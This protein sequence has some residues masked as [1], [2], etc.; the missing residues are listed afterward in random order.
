MKKNKIHRRD[1]LIDS[2]QAAMF[3]PA[4]DTVFESLLRSAIQPKMAHAASPFKTFIHLNLYAAPPRWMYDLFLNP[5]NEAS[6]FVASKQVTNRYQNTTGAAYTDATYSLVRYGTSGPYVPYLWSLA[7]PKSG[8][9]T[10]AANALLANMLNIRGIN[11]LNAAHAGAAELHQTAI[12]GSPTISS[13]TADKAVINPSFPTRNLIRSL[14][15]NGGIGNTFRSSQGHSQFAHN[16]TGNN[17]LAS[18]FAALQPISVANGFNATF[19]ANRSA[20]QDK[21]NTA[22]TS[23]SPTAVKYY[24][25]VLSASDASMKILSGNAI[26]T[27]TQLSNEWTELFGKYKALITATL[28]RTYNGINDK[29]I[30]R[31][32]TSTAEGRMY[33]FSDGEFAQNKTGTN[34]DLRGILADANADI[35]AGQF[36][37]TEFLVTRQLCPSINVTIPAFRNVRV[38]ARSATMSF[39]Q[40]FTGS[41]PGIFMNTMYYLSYTS[42]LLELIRVLKASNQFNDTLIYMASEFNRAARVDGSGADHGSMAGHV[43]L[44]SGRINAFKIIGNIYKDSAGTNTPYQANYKGTWGGGAPF[45]DN[46]HLNIVQVWASIMRTLGMAVPDIPNA[47]RKNRLIFNDVGSLSVTSLYNKAPLNVTNTSR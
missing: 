39:D 42:C 23:L 38:N 34:V 20:L 27:F 44:L 3:L 36:A 15:L 43:S 33:Q 31:E 8:G 9:G 35:L 2:A 41:M 11:V 45:V 17:D 18:M 29:R 25:N 1:F 26:D 22:L 28:G 5:T 19:V 21:L 32:Y 13:L 24:Q 37:V 14:S 30:G 10:I 12:V 6:K 7:V 4:V 40:H 47:V 46:V 16:V